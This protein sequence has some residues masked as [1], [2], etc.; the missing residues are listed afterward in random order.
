MPKLKVESLNVATLKKMAKSKSGAYDVVV[1]GDVV[2]TYEPG[3]HPDLTPKE[4]A[5]S[6]AKKLGGK[7]V[8]HGGK[9]ADEGDE[10]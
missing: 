1:D 5:E 9:D 3:C 6:Y 7:A 4:C 10:E 2:R 8:A